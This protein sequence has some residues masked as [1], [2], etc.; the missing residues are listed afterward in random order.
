MRIYIAGPLFSTAEREFNLRLAQ[1]L[2]EE[3]HDLQPEII[4]PQQKVAEMAGDPEFVIKTF[5]YCLETV[6]QCDYL[7]AL[8]EGSDAD[9]GTCIEL[10]YAYAQAKPIIGVRTDFRN[11]EDRGLN[12]MVANICTRLIYQPFQSTEDLAVDVAKVLR[13]LIDNIQN[14]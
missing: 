10:G 8:L 9:S 4:L 5:H 1:G 13:K 14:K 11:S 3:L 2:K 6:S 7:V 12:L